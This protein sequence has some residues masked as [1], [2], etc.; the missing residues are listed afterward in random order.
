MIFVAK[1][2]SLYGDLGVRMEQFEKHIICF[3]TNIYF[4]K[5]CL[6]RNLIPMVLGGQNCQ[7]GAKSLNLAIN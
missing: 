2:T 5:I 3:Q 1:Q 6:T 7:K 4:K